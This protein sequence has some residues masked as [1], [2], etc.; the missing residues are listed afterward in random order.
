MGRQGLYSGG[1]STPALDALAGLSLLPDVQEGVEAARQAC[2]ELRWHQALR[3]RIP[4]AAAESRVRGAAASALLEGA[5]PAGSQG[6]V[7]LVRDLMRG[8]ADWDARPEDPMWQVLAGVVR[9]TA[10]TEHVG[11]TQLGAPAQVLASLHTAAAGGLLPAAQVGRPRAAAEECREWAELPPAPAPAEVHDRLGL[12]HELLA[13]VP[14]GRAPVLLVAA[15]AHAEIVT[16]RPFVLGN[17]VV[18]R[19]VERV[20]L[21]VGGLDPT[22]VAVP[23]VGHTDRAGTD[24]RGALAAY[25]SGTSEGVRLWLLHCAEGARRAAAEGAR[26]ADA[27]LAGR[28]R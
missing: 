15:V 19:A 4:E 2:T 8:A 11:A 5:E 12:V 25:A 17:G 28:L 14:T 21:R 1:V 22:G 20:V 3:R 27:V 6:S 9:A 18:A 23:E 16:T 24:Y 7:D 10:A 13:A 26:I